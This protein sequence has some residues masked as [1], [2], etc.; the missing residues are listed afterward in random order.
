MRPASYAACSCSTLSPSAGD[1]RVLVANDL[2]GLQQA[3]VAAGLL[4]PAPP[5][6]P[7]P[8]PPKPPPNSPTR[9]KPPPPTPLKPSKPLPPKKPPRRLG[10]SPGSRP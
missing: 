7:K 3:D 4:A 10:P 2:G 1:V 9:P 6:K 8:W 5:V